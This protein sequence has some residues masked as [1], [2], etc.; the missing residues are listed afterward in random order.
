LTRHSPYPREDLVRAIAVLLPLVSSLPAAAAAVQEP[1]PAIADN[2]FL[3]E[4]AYNQEPGVVQ[5]ISSLTAAGA[6]RRDLYFSITQEW[7]F[8]SQRH[9][10]SYTVPVTRLDGREAGLGDVLLNYRLQIAGGAAR[11]A[12]AP[13]LS[14]ILPTG[15]VRRG[16]GDG[17]IG[18]QANLPLSIQ[19]SKAVVTHWNVGATV[20]PR[21]QG[22]VGRPRRTLTHVVLG[23]SVIAPVHLPVQVMVESLVSS[24]S[25][26][27]AGGS[28]RR[29]TAWVVSPGARA[30]LNFGSLQIV[31]GVAFPFTRTSGTTE[32]GTLLYLS[33]E[34]PFRPGGGAGSP[35]G[36]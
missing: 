32:R 14:V 15:S 4:E 20:L 8:R 5:H 12:L 16:L 24:E 2:S 10:L 28:V 7:P 21:A 30:A 9:Q 22:A 34:H 36:E 23:G 19:V 31:P 3:I 11:W 6:G 1:E 13:R 25:E 35:S 18:I 27:A 33:V 17:S 29:T 26:I